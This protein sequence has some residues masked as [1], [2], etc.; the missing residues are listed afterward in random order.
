MKTTISII[1]SLIILASCQSKEDE[2]QALNA[3]VIAIHDEV[4]PKMDE[5]MKLKSK[6]Q[7]KLILG[8]IE[9]QETE[10]I[11]S[12]LVELEEADQVMMNWMRNFDSLMEDKTEEDK[13]AYLETQKK[14]I[15]I[16]KDKMLSAI[17]QAESYLNS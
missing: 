1:L 13:I 6:L 3:E 5:I 9:E 17:S 12:L 7:Q 11:Q 4:M 10:K 16:V 8:D 15:Q 2:V 14:A